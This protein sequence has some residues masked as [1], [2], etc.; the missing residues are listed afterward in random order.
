MKVILNKLFLLL[1][2]LIIFSNFTYA[3]FAL[4]VKITD[5]RNNTGKVM[6]Q[7][8][9]EEEKVISQVMGDIKDKSFLFTAENLKAG[10]YAVRFYHDENLNQ[11]M[12][13]N[14]V[15]KPTEGYGFSNN[16]TEKFSMPKFEKWLFSL[17]QDTMIVLKTVY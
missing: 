2:G 7:V 16:V 4:K 13:T 11:N 5:L 14:L 9:D 12:E 8:F 3:Q 1:A 17:H 10:K 15:G 6:L